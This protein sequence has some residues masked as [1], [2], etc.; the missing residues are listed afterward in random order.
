MNTPIVEA[1]NSIYAPVLRA[2]EQFHRQ[3]NRFKVKYRY[4]RLVS[5]FKCLVGCA[6]DW[7]HALLIRIEQLGGEADSVI[8]KPPVVVQDEVKDAYEA[9][10]TLLREI[11]DAIDAAIESATKSG[12]RDNPT[13]KMLMMV[14]REVDHE[15]HKYDAYIRQVKDLGSNYLVTVVNPVK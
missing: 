10:L 15:I 1:L 11:Y 9:T 5:R 6:H 3:K 8:G 13:H 7:R 2:Y 14:Q 4:K 12:K